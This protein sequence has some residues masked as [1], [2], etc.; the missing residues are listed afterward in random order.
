MRRDMRRDMRPDMRRMRRVHT[1]VLAIAAL[2]VLI[3]FTHAARADVQ[4]SCNVVEIEGSSSD[5]PSLDPELKSLEK[6]LKKPPF[7]SWN[8]FKRLGAQTVTLSM[9]KAASVPLVHGKAELLL[10]DVTA[11]GSKKRRLSLGLLL[12][13]ADGKRVV[14]T[15]VSV[16]L[17]DWFM[18]ARSMKSNRGQVVAL[19]CKL[20]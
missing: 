18:L 7:S 19:T 14:D 16:D 20:L 13:D 8:T 1:S 15:K 4:V 2:A 9:M 5:A 12:D 10:R 11:P 6:K 17:G 3:G